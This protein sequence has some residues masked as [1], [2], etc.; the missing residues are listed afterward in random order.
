[1]FLDPIK[2]KRQIEILGLCFNNKEIISITDLSIILNVSFPTIERDLK[3]LRGKGIPINSVSGKGV[4]IDKDFDTNLLNKELL[5]YIAI[6]YS[7]NLGELIDTNISDKHKM[8][9]LEIFVIL[10]K[11]IEAKTKVIMK[12][13]NFDYTITIEPRLLLRKNREW[14]LIIQRDNS[15]KLIPLNNIE[16]IESTEDVFEINK[17]NEEMY[18]VID[19]ELRKREIKTYDIRLFFAKPINGNIPSQL[20]KVNIYSKNQDGSYELTAECNR[21]ED[22]VPWLLDNSSDVLILEPHELKEIIVKRAEDVL[23]KYK[24]QTD[25]QSSN[26]LYSKEFLHDYEKTKPIRKYY[27]PVTE[28]FYEIPINVQIEV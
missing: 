14:S 5:N 23:K 4:I 27:N 9:L 1:M 26:I 21:L 20:L 8:H 3:E 7:S 18:K 6:C 25:F 12:D 10:Q 24:Q 13:T 15:F 19:N 22:L 28:N 17:A 16:K 2:T 11:S